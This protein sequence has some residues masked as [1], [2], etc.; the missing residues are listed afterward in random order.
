MCIP[1]PL[2]MTLFKAEW[3]KLDQT[4]QQDFHVKAKNKVTHRLNKQKVKQA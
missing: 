2:P 4:R 1:K 3:D